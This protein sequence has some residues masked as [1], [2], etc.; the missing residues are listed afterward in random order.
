MNISTFYPA[1]TISPTAQTT[2]STI[3]IATDLGGRGGLE[4]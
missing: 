4:G 2:N 3:Q 1:L